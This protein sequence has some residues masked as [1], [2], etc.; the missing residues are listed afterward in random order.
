M[1]YQLEVIGFIVQRFVGLVLDVVADLLDVV[2]I[3]FVEACRLFRLVSL[4]IL[5]CVAARPI[6]VMIVGGFG[7][8]Q[9]IG[10]D[11]LEFASLC[12]VDGRAQIMAF[13][14]PLAATLFYVLG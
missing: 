4:G 14:W 9:F 13:R 2:G 6:L 11:V 7:V 10:R 3:A 5:D 8:Q 12:K 1:R